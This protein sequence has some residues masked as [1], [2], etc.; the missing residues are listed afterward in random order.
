MNQDIKDYY[1]EY[2]DYNPNTGIAIWKKSPSNRVKVGDEIKSKDNAGYIQVS[3]KSK[4]YRLHRIIWFCEKGEIPKQI[5]HINGIRDDNRMCNLRNVSQQENLKNQ[6][7]R[8]DNTSGYSGISFNKSRN[9]WRVRI[10]VDKK[11]KHLGY[12]NTIEEAIDVRKQAEVDY[13]YHC[14]HGR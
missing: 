14:N 1:D 9:K 3:I 5:D 4:M 10:Y 8:C 12:F 2:I 11:E 7:K 6:K 13:G